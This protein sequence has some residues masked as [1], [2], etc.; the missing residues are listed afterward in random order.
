MRRTRTRPLL[1]AMIGAWLIATVVIG[2]TETAGADADTQGVAVTCRSAT[3]FDNLSPANGPS[4]A[5]VTMTPPDRVGYRY[6]WDADWSVVLHYRTG[7]WGFMLRRCH[8][9]VNSVGRHSFTTNPG[10]QRRTVCA[11]DVYVRDPEMRVVGRLYHDQT[12]AIERY[13]TN[14]LGV[15]GVGFAHGDVNKHGY[16][17]AREFC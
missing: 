11:T 2:A 17:L 14:D 12:M 7:Q 9:A 13:T 5:R 16:V 3:L 6:S 1:P 8:G 15:L 10:N 4:G